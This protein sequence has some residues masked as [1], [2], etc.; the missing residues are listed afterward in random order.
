MMKCFEASS[1][2]V[3]LIMKLLSLQI[4]VLRPYTV[5]QVYYNI[6]ATDCN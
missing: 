2:K 6:F 4:N 1:L 5:A 3:S